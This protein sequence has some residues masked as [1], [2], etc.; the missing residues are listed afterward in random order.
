MQEWDKPRRVRVGGSEEAKYSPPPQ[1][2]IDL[3]HDVTC[4]ECQTKMAVLDTT[5]LFRDIQ[6]SVFN[7]LGH[8]KIDASLFLCYASQ[9]VA[10]LFC[11]RARECA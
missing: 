11:A 4:S 9:D 10:D 2:P 7:K 3:L 1:Y 6:T 5:R 8:W